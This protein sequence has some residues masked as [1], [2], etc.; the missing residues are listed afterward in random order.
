[1]RGISQSAVLNILLASAPALQT[2]FPAGIPLAGHMKMAV[3]I[4]GVHSQLG[5]ARQV[6]FC[7]MGGFDT[8][9]A[10]L[11]AYGGQTP[12]HEQLSQ[13][14]TAFTAS[15]F[16]R[17]VMPTATWQPITPGLLSAV[18]DL[19]NETCCFFG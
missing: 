6:F 12:L 17:T 18:W 15:E 10:Q 19:E 3:R 2:V 8:H 4:I 7:N 5:L 13:N 14:V 1:L 9:S 11:N 16:G